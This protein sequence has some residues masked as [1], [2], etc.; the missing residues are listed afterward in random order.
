MNKTSIYIFAI[1]LIFASCDEENKT[2][3]QEEEKET[4]VIENLALDTESKWDANI[5]TTDGIRGMETL[6]SEF[7]QSE[8]LRHYKKL[9]RKLK[10]I[11]KKIDKECT[12][13]G[14]SLENLDAFLVPVSKYISVLKSTKSIPEAKKTIF[15]LQRHLNEY[16][17]FF[18]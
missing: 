7:V 18:K 8:K 10:K 1:L 11:H 2:I 15:S 13:E 3:A 9:G 14:E 4:V 5:E 6:L 16:Y 17:T 12:M